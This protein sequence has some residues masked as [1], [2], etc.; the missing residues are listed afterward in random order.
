[1]KEV[2]FKIQLLTSMKFSV[3]LPVTVNADNV[4]AI[5]ME[6]NVTTTSQT[7]HVDIRYKYVNECV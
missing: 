5:F 1:M 6:N 4:G 2:I 3:N 7:K